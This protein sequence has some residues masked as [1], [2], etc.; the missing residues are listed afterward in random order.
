MTIPAFLKT[1]SFWAAI[2]MTNVGLLLSNG[3]LGDGQTAQGA[4]WALTILTV[5]GYKALTSPKA[6]DPAPADTTTA[7]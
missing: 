3:Y 2:I 5:L 4:G 7:P 6:P 1:P